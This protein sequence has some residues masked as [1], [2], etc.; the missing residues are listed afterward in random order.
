MR[1]VY[2]DHAATTYLDPRVKDAMEPYWVEEYG[3]PSSL[4]RP[5]RRA[6]DALD[7]A[8][9]TIARILNCRPEELIF[10]G[11]GTEAINLAIFGIARLYA[12]Q[13]SPLTKGGALLIP[14]VEKIEPPFSS[15]TN[16]VSQSNGHLITSAIEHHAVLH[17]MEALEKEGFGITKVGVDEYGLVD[18]EKLRVAVRPDTILISVMYA[19]NEIGTIEPIEE[20]GRVIKEVRD[21]RKKSGNSTPIFFHTDACQAAGALDLDVQKL[22]ADLLAMNGSK[23][24]GPKGVGCL[25]IRKGIRLKPLIYGGGQENNLRS[26]TENVPGIIGF[27]KALEIAHKEKEKENARLI[28]LR[29]YFIN[30]LLTEIPKVVLNGPS[31]EGE[32][33]PTALSG[34]FRKRLPNNINVSVLDIEGEAVILYLDAKGI[35]CSTG[36]ACTSTTLDPSHVILAIG[37]P[38]EYAH[39]SIRFTLGRRTTKEDIDYVMEVFPGV[40]ETLRKISPIRL[41]IG[42]TTVSHPEAFAGQGSKVK[43]GGK[44]YK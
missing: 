9:G 8:R 15:R 44:N 33:R 38:Y 42:Q 12:R 5:G 41:E 1:E 13:D 24:Y 16:P 35:Y 10:T 17:S 37:R 32:A 43:V 36:S 14:P 21:E 31:P 3:N 4:Y 6:K 27:A 25:Y 2:L 19:N 40:V 23:I 20:I 34:D 7:N 18:P 39:G 11:G 29:D 28:E 30:R 22:G 26:G